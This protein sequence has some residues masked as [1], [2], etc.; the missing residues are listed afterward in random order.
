VSLT[1]ALADTGQALETLL[2][3]RAIGKLV[4]TP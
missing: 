2:N 1:F 3:R 4:I